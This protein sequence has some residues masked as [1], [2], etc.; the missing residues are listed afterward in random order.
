MR[1]SP[2][3]DPCSKTRDT[4]T[5]TLSIQYL[6]TTG[7]VLTISTSFGPV[8]SHTMITSIGS[9][10]FFLQVPQYCRVAGF[11]DPRIV[12]AMGVNRDDAAIC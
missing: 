9:F 10:T 7:W 1:R 4:P 8:P 3:P 2:L 12:G 6:L 11:E 5:L